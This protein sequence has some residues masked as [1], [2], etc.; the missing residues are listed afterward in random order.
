MERTQGVLSLHGLGGGGAILFLPRALPTKATPL[1]PRQACAV[2]VFP[3]CAFSCYILTALYTVFITLYIFNVYFFLFFYFFY[4][5][6]KYHL[7]DT[8]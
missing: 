4:L 5:L 3:E 1:L 7:S 8:Q 2:T 6:C